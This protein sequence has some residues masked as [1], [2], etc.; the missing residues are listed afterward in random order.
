MNLQRARQSVALVALL[1]LAAVAS[2]RAASSPGGD[3]ALRKLLKFPTLQVEFGLRLD[4]VQ[5]LRLL[6]DQRLHRAEIESLTQALRSNPND[7]E[8][9][10]R[11]AELYRK[12]NEP[13]KASNSLTRA[14]ELYRKLADAQSENA[15]VIARFGH[16]L[17]AAG[18]GEEAEAV[19]RRAVKL[20]ATDWRCWS[21][22]SRVLI[23]RAWAPLTQGPVPDPDFTPDLLLARATRRDIPPASLERAERNFVEA[24]QSADR[25]IA[26]A[27]R[28]PG[29]VAHHAL[30]VVNFA[31]FQF[32]KNVLQGAEPDP[33]KFYQALFTTNALPDFTR[34]ADLSAEDPLLITKVA[35]YEVMASAVLSGKSGLARL[36]SGEIW[37]QLEESRR[38][39]IRQALTRLEN[40]S[41]GGNRSNAALAYEM[42]GGLQRMILRDQAGAETSLRGAIGLDPSRDLAWDLLMSLR[43]ESGRFSD[44]LAAAETRLQTKDSPRNRLAAMKACERLG[45]LDQAQTHADAAL[46]LSPADYLANL[47]AAILLLKRDSDEASLARAKQLLDRAS[48]V[49]G[50]PATRDEWGEWTLTIAIYY[51]LSGDQAAAR[52]EL[53]RL[54][55]ADPDNQAGKEALGIVGG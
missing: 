54:L 32:I 44:A 41:Q 27:P 48:Q 29:A 22:L 1:L 49:P 38:Q 51:A 35:L 34:L 14:V 55:E 25:A 52:R 2:V 17:D 4:L 8:R 39:S 19:L 18:R 37:N 10:S 26:L 33:V 9:T 53:K 36:S 16:A 40:L 28:E 45:H 43:I 15:E 7:A 46:K 5:G 30:C 42:R 47:S 50:R 12:T 6:G 13:H 20:G 11:L 24:R 21:G 23:G 3:S 31:L